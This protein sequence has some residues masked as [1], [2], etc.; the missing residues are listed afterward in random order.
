MAPLLKEEAW[1]TPAEYLERERKS[2]FRNEYIGGK[3]FRRPDSDRAHN[4]IAGNIAT[5]L[6]A[7]LRGKKCRTFM[8][9]MKFRLEFPNK[10]TV[11]YYPDVMVSCRP[12]ASNMHVEYPSVIIE[13][14]SRDT[15]DVDKREKF[16]SYTGTASVDAYV[17]VDQYR[18]DVVAYRR[19]GESWQ[20]DHFEHFTDELYLPTLEFNLSIE[21]I[22]EGAFEEEA[23]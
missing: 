5:A 23:A 10:Q 2:L 9:D 3:V 7:H 19:V 1:L 21:A 20:T 11:F 13:V 6:H 12:E 4:V 22:Y 18:R 16:F 8:N 17:L 14:L 15:E